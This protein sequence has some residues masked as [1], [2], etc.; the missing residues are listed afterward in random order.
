MIDYATCTPERL[1]V[2]RA[3]IA[4]YLRT[5]R[6]QTPAN[7]ARQDEY[8]IRLAKIDQELR[9]RWPI[10]VH[11]GEQSMSRKSYEHY[12]VVV[13]MPGYLPDNDVEIYHRKRDAH[14]SALWYANSYRELNDDLT[15][16]DGKYH[17]L[18]SARSGGYVVTRLGWKLLITIETCFDSICD[19][20]ESSPMT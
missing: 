4:A 9:N 13:N 18:G 10:H 11:K 5:R 7:V 20:Y 3:F 12:H 15:P 19:D 17:V 6:K 16:E 8:K 1:K 14:S 2:D